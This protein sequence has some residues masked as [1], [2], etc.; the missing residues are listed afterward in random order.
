ML[1][2]LTNVLRNVDEGGAASL[3]VIIASLQDSVV[4]V[5]RD[6]LCDVVPR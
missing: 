1:Q 4:I 2:G 5:R 6:P 3:S